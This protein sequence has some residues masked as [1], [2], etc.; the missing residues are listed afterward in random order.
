MLE[1]PNFGVPLD[2]C[3]E[4]EREGAFAR[5]YPYFYAT[6]GGGGTISDM[7]AIGEEM[8]RDMKAEDLDGILLVST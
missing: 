4:L 5:L 3:R 6:S 1:N 8:A 2:A 7:R